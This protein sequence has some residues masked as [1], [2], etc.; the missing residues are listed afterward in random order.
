M[1]SRVAESLYWMARYIERAE[2]VARFVH[3]N[4]NLQLDAPPGAGEQWMPLVTTSGDDDL[5][6]Q[7][8]TSATRENVIRF[9]TTDLDNR[10]SI[11][12]CVRLA[13]ENARTVREAI[14]SEMWEAINSMFLMVNAAAQTNRPTDSPYEFYTAVKQASQIIDG[15]TDSTMSHGEAW[16]FV[17][18]GRLIERADKTSRI[19]DVKYFILLPKLEDVGSPLDSIQWSALLKSASALEMYRKKY[20][21]IQPENILR[22]LILDQEFPRAMLHC[23]IHAQRCLHAVS[24]PHETSDINMAERLLGR[25]RSDL[26]YATV[27]DVIAF[28]IHEYLD[29][30]QRRLNEVGQAIFDT[31][32]ALRPEPA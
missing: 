32:F 21:R 16:H 31:Y 3:V 28:G 15:V 18:L 30:F 2:N 24:P 8:Y 5:F 1:L 17:H 12:S 9:L 29:E 10:N 14:S 23:L 7:L 26:T 4:L 27:D 20:Q 6:T 22:F 11:L 13:R 19:V 25:L